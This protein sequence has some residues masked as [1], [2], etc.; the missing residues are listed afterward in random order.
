MGVIMVYKPTYNWGPHHLQ[1]LK[2]WTVDVGRRRRRAQNGILNRD[3][4]IEVWS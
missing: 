1:G 3:K 2:Q 4:M